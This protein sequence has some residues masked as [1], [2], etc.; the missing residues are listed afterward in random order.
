MRRLAAVLAV[1]T[2]PVAAVLG[3][4]AAPVSAVSAA[5]DAPLDARVTDVRWLP[6]QLSEFAGSR[7]TVLFFTTVDC[8]IARRYLSRIGELAAAHSDS[9]V[10]VLVVGVDPHDPLVR[11]AGQQVELAPRATF[12]MDFDGALARAAGVDRTATALVLDA[13]RRVVYRG[14]VDG[15]YRY[16][17]TTP[18]RGR[19]DLRLALED[20]LAG[21]APEVATTAVEGCRIDAAASAAAEATTSAAPTFHADIAPLLQR[22]CQDCHRDGGEA[23]FALESLQDCRRRL[24]MIGEVVAQR[25]MPPWYGDRRH[26]EF[27][28]LR[29][30]DDQE[31]ATVA[32]WVAAGGPEGDPADAPP[33]RVWPQQEW[34]IGEPDLVLKVPVPI[35][36]PADGY[37]P[38]KYFVLPF[39]FAE[40]TWVEAIEIKPSVK[41]ALHHCNLARAAWGTPFSQD[42][43]VT[44]QVP[45]G[46]AMVLDPG[47]AVRIPKGSA[48]VLQAHYVTTGQPEVDRLRV[49]LRFPRGV[50]DKE[51]RVLIVHDRRFAIPPGAAAHPVE[52]ARTLPCDARGIGLFVHMHL[53]GR[54]MSVLAEPPDG[55]GETLLVVPNYN[56]DWQQSFRWEQAGRPF[57]KGTR[58]RALAHFDNS[59]SNPFNP[60]PGATVRFGQQ[61]V[62]EMMYAFLFYT[63]EGERL[64][65]R[66]DP[67]TGHVV[68]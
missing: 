1:A 54:D 18:G 45:G 31:R 57:A 15:Q 40:D 66:V 2:A 14:R 25:R 32:R 17:G 58:I 29:A 37:L 16:A 38:Y 6:R 65:L 46:D 12:V 9:G 55:A 60:D 64:G 53:R 4:Q 41:N 26:T 43:F 50:V 3:Q 8:P 51:L 19:E 20:V 62:D 24:E 42:G 22:H 44:G 13:G 27:V 59:A 67:A 28:N 10:R 5:A 39:H 11:A 34:R 36:L 7:A 35:R 23:P 63:Q 30:L 68:P 33:P 21:R 52:A 49:G 61:T 47:T 48:L 56:F